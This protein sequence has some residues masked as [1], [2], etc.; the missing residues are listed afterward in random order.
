[1][2]RFWSRPLAVSAALLLAALAALPQSRRASAEP[3]ANFKAYTEAVPGT[4]VP[5][6]MV[7][8]PAGSFTMGSPESEA[9]RSPDEGP[10]HRVT[11]SNGFWMSK[12]EVLWDHYDQFYKNEGIPEGDKRR[13]EPVVT[14]DAVTRPTPHYTDDTWG[15]GR[16]GKPCLGIMHHS[17]QMF[18]VWLSRKTGKTYRLPTEA[19]WEYACRAGSTT[20]YPWGNDPAKLDEYEWF[21]KNADEDTHEPGKKK[22][23][24][25]GLH[26]MLGNV[27]EWCFDH[28][29]ANDYKAMAGKELVNPFRKPTAFKYSHVVRGG[30]FAD[31]AAKCR[32]ATRR[33]S[34][35]TWLKRDPQRPQSIW[36]MT[37][38]DWVGFRVV[39]TVNE[40]PELKGYLPQV[41]WK[42]RD[43][44][45][46]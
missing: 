43:T 45:D 19:E 4:T 27:A 25:F 1:M 36:W 10:Q 20:A 21:A 28:Y 8:I 13:D 7:P 3:I 42:S 18:C 15:H 12:C 35:K 41:D 38:C 2:P 31:D 23:N 6:D 14:A 34:E 9:G 37:D 30:S 33:G 11:I 39:R 40:L 29:S 32:S 44:D 24:A 46:K 17:A 22:P 16:E 5:L 26:D